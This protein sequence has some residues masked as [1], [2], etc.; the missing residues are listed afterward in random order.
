MRHS[1]VLPPYSKVRDYDGKGNY[2]IRKYYR[3]PY[4]FFYRH[5]LRM[6]LKELDS[7]RIYRNLLDFGSGPAEIFR[8]SLE[9]HAITVKCVDTLSYIDPRWKFD[10][11][12]CA[13][14]LEFVDLDFTVPLLKS[15]IAPNGM[16]IGASPMKTRLSKLY[17]SLIKDSS[18]RNS[19]EAIINSISKHFFLVGQKEWFGLY[20][21]FKAYP[22]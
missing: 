22:K 8:E 15:I 16:L 5:K 9:R 19:H 6:I 7:K 3:L 10:V 1:L 11:V 17:F 20:F 14:V 2:A 21:S 13:S 4:S 12:V 18:K